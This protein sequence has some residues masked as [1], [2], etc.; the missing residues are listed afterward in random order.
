MVV[1]G[2]DECGRGSLAGPLVACG[3][4]FH[5]SFEK[6]LSLLSAPLRDSKKMTKIQRD[7]VFSQRGELPIT[8]AVEIIRVED[9]NAH[10]IDWANRECFIRLSQKISADR[11]LVDGNIKFTSSNFMSVVHGD[12]IYPEIMLASILGKV[13]RDNIMNLLHQ[14]FPCYSW[15]TNAGYGSKSHLEGLKEFGLSPHHRT[16]FA[17]TAL[18]HVD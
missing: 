7:R 17:K 11:Y 4:I 1:C 9:I 8:Y 10:G 12:N 5:Q 13:T 6:I 16:V 3:V 15:N 14:D 2:L 18:S